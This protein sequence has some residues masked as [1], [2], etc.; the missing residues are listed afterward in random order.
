M[1]IKLE[2][3]EIRDIASDLIDDDAFN[4][5]LINKIR[6]YPSRDMEL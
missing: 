2:F 4:D 1:N 6:S 5:D 3:E